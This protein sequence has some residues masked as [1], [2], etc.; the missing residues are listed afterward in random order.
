MLEF[1]P[2]YWMNVALEEAKKAETLDEV[3]IGAVLVDLKTN[4]LISKAHNVVEMTYNALNHAEKLCLE[5]AMMMLETKVLPNTA[6]FVTLEPCPMCAT[7]ISFAR[8]EKCYFAAEDKKA[9]AVINNTKLPTNHPHFFKT[10]YIH[11]TGKFAE[12]SE[13]LLKNFFKKLRK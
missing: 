4:S 3:P 10:E 8:V 5:H 7:A 11:L 13:T 9:G 1:N 12:Q 6:L 2:D